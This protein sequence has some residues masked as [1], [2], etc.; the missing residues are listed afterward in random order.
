MKKGA[1]AADAKAATVARPA[2]AVASASAS[3]SASATS[4]ASVPSAVARAAKGQA[5][6]GPAPVV[7][8]IL[9]V[10]TREFAAHG[11]AGAR[12]ERIVQH[13][14]TSKR[15]IYYHFGSKEGLFRAVLDH[16]FASVRKEDHA[17]DP[18]AG[19]PEQALRTMVGNAFRAFTQ[20]P[21]FVRLLT[22]ENLSGA[23]FIRAS[24]LV[25]H[26]NRRAMADMQRVIERG[27]HEGTIR[28]D[29][30][31]IHVYINMVGLCYYHVAHQAGYRAG[32]FGRRLDRSF[33]G[34]AF[35][36]QRR[37]AIEDACWRYVRAD[38]GR[39]GA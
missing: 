24:P 1:R 7:A 2:K 29:I 23:Q 39:P 31:A 36:R 37:R 30:R 32:G 19:T 8:D 6:A 33:G 20:H 4:V 34:A 26:L 27:Q 3:A 9:Q 10:A 16:A 13:T 18:D 21:E 28:S 11:L 22:Y 35:E 15:M 14:R 17:F 5:A 38:Q 12:V 25:S